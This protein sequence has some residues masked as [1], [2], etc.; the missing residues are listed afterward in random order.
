MK[1][2]ILIAS[3]FIFWCC[4]RVVLWLQP[5]GSL[6][7]DVSF[8]RVVQDRHGHLV[9]M[10]LA[11][12]DIYRVRT[13][14]TDISPLAVHA[15][16]LY[17]D[18]YFYFHPGVNP[19][20]LIRAFWTTFVV[21]KRVVGAST[22]TMQLARYLHKIDSRTIVGKLEQII[23]ALQLEFLYSKDDILEAYLN[24]VPYGHNIEGIGAASQIYFQKEATRL[25]LLEALTLAVIPQSPQERTCHIKEQPKANEA[26][27]QAREVLVKK[28][29]QTYPE[30]LDKAPDFS[31]ELDMFH[32]SDLP[33][34]APHL[35]TDVLQKSPKG[36]I[37]TTMDLS[38]QS[39]F[40][41]VIE[42]YINQK[43]DV[44]ISN[45]SAMLIDSDTMETLAVIGSA[46][47]FS[48][49]ISGQVNGTRAR[50]SPGSALK[51]FAYALA[52]EQGVIHPQTMLKDAPTPFGTYTP[53]NFDRAFSGPISATEALIHSRNIPAIHVAAGI[54][55]PDLYEFLSNAGIPLNQD[56]KHY[57]L[58][59]VLGTAE[60]TMEEIVMLYAMLNNNGFLRPLK[61]LGDEPYMEGRQMLTPESCFLIL[62]MLSQNP[63]PEG[64]TND[65]WLLE[66]RRVAW[67]TGTSV[68]YR[69]AWSIGVFDHYVMAV[70]VG[71]FSGE[72]NP[73]FIGRHAAGPLLFKLIQALT[74][75]REVNFQEFLPEYKL[76]VTEIEVCALSGQIPHRDCPHRKKSWFIPGVSPISLCQVHR[77]LVID[78]ASGLQVCPGF[79]GATTSGVFEFWPTDLLKLFNQAG[80]GRR[81]PPALHPLCRQEVFGDIPPKIIT[82]KKDIV[83]HL[84]TKGA[85]SKQIPLIAVGDG[86]VT[87]FSWYIDNQ[88]LG[89][90]KTQDPLL[91][92]ARPGQ[93]LVRVI[94]D[95]GRQDVS[96]ISIEWVD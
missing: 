1:L 77:R 22:I 26:L 5:T 63:G 59:L 3:L 19:A 39:S 29:M 44:G 92:D 56:P 46:D 53:D 25:S 6:L 88:L 49:V 12:D 28:W 38:I 69:D 31:L 14:L 35:T 94:D 83:Y 67:K 27:C 68:G 8:S 10:T 57:G 34:R 32:P 48:E 11:E 81:I 37:K 64:E 71:N 36:L 84:R 73:A 54:S 13:A 70:W 17:E 51:P 65:R 43:K 42:K 78:I 20:S 55:D 66:P 90:S 50:R 24:I 62:E 33:F 82:P 4:H 52:M 45:A 95:F 23:R 74:K 58:S 85:D 80:I 15:T 60:V 7:D 75:L 16:L 18:R 91:W 76:N 93:H 96:L 40:E 89:R 21:R 30:N 61:K 47:F 2:R 86:N 72:G 87:R 79:D 41:A 9:Q